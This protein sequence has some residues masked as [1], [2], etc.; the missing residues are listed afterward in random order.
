MRIK[1]VF[2]N[3]ASSP[4]GA[5]TLALSGLAWWTNAKSLSNK[6]FILKDFFTYSRLDF[7]QVGQSPG[8]MLVSRASFLNFYLY[9]AAILT[10]SMYKCKEL[11]LLF[12]FSSFE[13]HLFELGRP[14]FVRCAVIY[15]PT[16]YNEDFLNEYSELLD[17]WTE[18]MPKYD[19]IVG[20][21]NI[22]VCCPDKLLK[23]IF[24]CW[25]LI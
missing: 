2:R 17:F 5:Y 1:K 21:F 19:L 11:S 10:Q 18:I 3:C 6:T 8:W 14:H 16:N 20:D 22:H 24:S 7:F 23:M 4:F 9:I 13:L 25:L 15:R 12:S